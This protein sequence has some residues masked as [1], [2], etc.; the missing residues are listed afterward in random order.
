MDAKIGVLLS[1]RSMGASTCGFTSTKAVL[2]HSG[3]EI[4]DQYPLKRDGLFAQGDFHLLSVGR[5]RVAIQN[6]GRVSVNASRNA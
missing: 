3:A 4:A 6:H 1:G 2:R 5:K